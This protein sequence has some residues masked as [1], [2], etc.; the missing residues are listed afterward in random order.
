[1][2]FLNYITSRKLIIIIFLI[3]L[4]GFFLRAWKLTTSPSA[5]YIDETD[6]GYNAFSVLTN[7]RDE[8]GEFMP[9]FFK[10]F[11]DYKPPLYIYEVA[12]AQFF[13]GPTDLSVRIPAVL[14]GSLTIPMFFLL[15][16]ELLEN[17]KN[18]IIKKYLPLLSAFLL[19]TS[20]W[21]IQFTRAGFGACLII[22]LYSLALFLFF[23]AMRKKS[24]I[25]LLASMISFVLT[26]YSYYSPR[27][28]TPLI[29]FL[30]VVFY[31][32]K[33]SFSN[34][35]LTFCIAGILAYPVISFSFTDEG[36][37]R[38]RMISIFYQP[39][40]YPVFQQ[41]SL[42]YLA[43]ISPYRLFIYGDPTIAHLTPHRMSLIYII[44]FP[45]LVMGIFSI[46]L[47]RN[48]N[49]LL[50]V[51]IFFLGFIPPALTITHPHALRGVVVL[52]GSTF[53][54]SFGF[55]FL[56]QMF[57]N[58]LLQRFSFAIYVGLIMLLTFNFLNI[59]HNKYVVDAGWD[60]QVDAKKVGLKLLEIEK[61][62]EGIY[63]NGGLRNIAIIWYIK[64]DPV[65]Y[66]QSIN[67]NNIGKYHFEIGS[68]DLVP[69]TGKNLFITNTQVKN[70]QLLDNI[71]YPNGQLAYKIWTI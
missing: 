40:E 30:L 3:T 20:S 57:K 8:H 26:L 62:Y 48:R 49:L 43:N 18:K 70:G 2:P 39:I 38:A 53:I 65:L 45:F 50:I 58:K 63:I 64:Y 42:N 19:A 67:K 66:Q 37:A 6:I 11:G 56:L 61:D 23:Q 29:L 10:S 69:H 54:S 9:L 34:W 33:F 55:I 22:F 52:L 21:H 27:I 51:I 68:E 60:W 36:L 35:L 59:Y 4:L 71:Y 17:F 44:E 7:G 13:L 1:M 12:I 15:A 32:K 47:M 16:K 14:I 24:T 25:M 41:L 31:F 28:I 46:L 5:L